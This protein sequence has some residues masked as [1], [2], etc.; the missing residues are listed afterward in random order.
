[1]ASRLAS[2]VCVGSSTS[3]APGGEPQAARPSAPKKT[4]TP[5]PRRSSEA[6]DERHALTSELENAFRRMGP[7]R[8]FSKIYDLSF[9]PNFTGRP[10]LWQR[11][12]AGGG[13]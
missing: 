6:E 4:T 9:A 8:S 11:I 13:S 5:T 2:L 3:N 7:T 12:G 10:G 1:M